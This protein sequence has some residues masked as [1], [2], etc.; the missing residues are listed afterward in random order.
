MA[1]GIW[2]FC[3]IVSDGIMNKRLRT[4]LAALGAVT[5]FILFL[6]V[7]TSLP[8]A[9]IGAAI[10]FCFIWLLAGFLHWFYTKR[11]YYT[12]KNLEYMNK[13]VS[14]LSNDKSQKDEELR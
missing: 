8:A 1:L 2:R 5:F 6:G 9:F 14:E 7:F 11:L 10:G 3:R 4:A 13:R 12:Q